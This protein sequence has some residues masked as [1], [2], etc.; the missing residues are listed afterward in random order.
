MV[1]FSLQQ[2][3]PVSNIAYNIGSTGN[4][5]ILLQIKNVTNNTNLEIKFTFDKNIFIIDGTE[6]RV[7]LQPS[8]VRGFNMELNK[9]QLNESLR[10]L[11]TKITVEVKNILN[12]TVVTKDISA[13]TLTIN[14]LPEI[15]NFSS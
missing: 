10:S 11:L 14:N 13:T 3:V 9:T 7:I 5:R 15:V 2:T 12:G 8:E 6:S 4:I 1:S